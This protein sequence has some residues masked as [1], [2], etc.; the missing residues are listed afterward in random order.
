[1]QERAEMGKNHCELVVVVSVV[2]MLAS[3]SWDRRS[4]GSGANQPPEWQENF[5]DKFISM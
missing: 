4:P 2:D 3:P 1:M 5:K